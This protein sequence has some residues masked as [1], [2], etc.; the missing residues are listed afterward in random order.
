[1]D[2]DVYQFRLE[3][4]SAQLC[5]AEAVLEQNELAR[6]AKMSFP[7]RTRSIIARATLRY[8]LGER[9]DISPQDLFFVYGANGKPALAPGLEGSISFN[10]AHSGDLAVVAIGQGAPIGVDLEEAREEINHELLA[11]D[12]FSSRELAR[13]RVLPTDKSKGAFYRAWTCKEAFVKATGEGVARSFQSI[14]IEVGQE[15]AVRMTR[16]PPEWTSVPWSLTQLETSPGFAGALA[17]GSDSVTIRYQETPAFFYP[18][19]KGV[20]AF[21]ESSHV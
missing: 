2:V 4:N 19:R 18:Y 7:W 16:I 3:A 12:I 11:P 21:K 5:A 17:V 15:K 9:L 6:F 8:L 10:L 20:W 13:F 1:M 14:E